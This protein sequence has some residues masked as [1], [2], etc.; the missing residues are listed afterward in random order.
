VSQQGTA[1]STKPVYYD[2][3]GSSAA[4]GGGAVSPVTAVKGEVDYEALIK[5]GKHVYV[6][7]PW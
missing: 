7:I 6:G 1:L 4:V 3:D 2:P 5:V